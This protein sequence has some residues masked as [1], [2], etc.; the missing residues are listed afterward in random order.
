M[1]L[2]STAPVDR[3]AKAAIARIL[4]TSAATAPVSQ[5]LADSLGIS[6]TIR[7]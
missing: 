4:R 6:E 2:T 3:V 1:L 5:K 7:S